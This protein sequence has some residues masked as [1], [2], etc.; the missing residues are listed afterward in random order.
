MFSGVQPNCIIFELRSGV[1][2]WDQLWIFGKVYS[3]DTLKLLRSLRVKSAFSLDE[4]CSPKV[5]LSS[6][7]QADQICHRLWCLEGEPVRLRLDPEERPKMKQGLAAQVGWGEPIHS[8]FLRC[9]AESESKVTYRNSSAGGP[10]A[11]KFN[12]DQGLLMLLRLSP[13]C[14][15]QNEERGLKW[16]VENIL[17]WV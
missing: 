10:R 8:R 7:Y 9:R 2:C 12:S 1:C 15:G 13:Y 14:G 4:L 16:T 11:V 3:A 5:V 6:D 17:L